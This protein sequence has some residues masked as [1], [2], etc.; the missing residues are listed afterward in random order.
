MNPQYAGA[1][2]QYFFDRCKKFSFLTKYR[3]GIA[4]MDLI[5]PHILM[6]NRYPMSYD[7]VDELLFFI[8]VHST[9]QTSKLHKSLE[10]L[11]SLR[12]PTLYVYGEK[13]KLIKTEWYSEMAHR[14]GAEQ[15]DVVIYS[16]DKQIEKVSECENWIKVLVLRGGGHF[17][18]VKYN[19]EV[20]KHLIHNCLQSKL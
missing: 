14:L 5:K 3:L 13:D 11:Q 12:I 20:C 7:S 6:R 4:F 17:G 1:K 2:G 19:E 15:K 16:E 9:I 18:F 8:L 10:L